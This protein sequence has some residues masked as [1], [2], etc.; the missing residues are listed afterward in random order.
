MPWPARLNHLSR[1]PLEISRGSNN[2]HIRKLQE[3][4]ESS[5]I[6]DERATLRLHDETQSGSD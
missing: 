4:P 1:L 2:A 3:D 6:S 5:P